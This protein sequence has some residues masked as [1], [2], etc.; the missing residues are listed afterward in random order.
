[1]ATSASVAEQ[2]GARIA[3]LLPPPVPPLASAGKPHDFGLSLQQRSY[4]LQQR[5][6]F[7]MH[8]VLQYK[9][10][11]RR[12]HRPHLECAI[13][14]ETMQPSIEALCRLPC[15]HEYHRACI[16]TWAL[17]QPTCP[18]DRQPFGRL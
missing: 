11:R 7:Q 17:R 4:K 5:Q 12:R 14:L 3:A 8:R 15:G 16:D 1:M 2:I 6:R 18:F 9:T 13:C 10:L